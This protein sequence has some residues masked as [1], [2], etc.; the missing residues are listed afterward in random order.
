MWIAK[1]KPIFECFWC[2][3][4][5]EKKEF[6]SKTIQ[7]ERVYVCQKCWYY[8]APSIFNNK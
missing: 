1:L 7:S 6:K 5:L 2:K 4:I 3:K 8:N